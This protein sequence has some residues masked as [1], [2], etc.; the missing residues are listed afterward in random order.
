MKSR[1]TIPFIRSS[2]W[3]LIY[4]EGGQRGVAMGV[5][6]GRDPGGSLVGAGRFCILVRGGYT[7]NNV[8]NSHNCANKTCALP[9]GQ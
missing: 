7:E 1:G 6:T 3:K 2:T 4:E 5:L 9:T 8:Y